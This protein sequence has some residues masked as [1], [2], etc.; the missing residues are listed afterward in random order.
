MKID[1]IFGIIY[2]LMKKDRLSARQLASH[3]E[4]ST[5]TI[6]RDIES[7]MQA[8]IPLYTSRG[9]EGG[10]SL[11]ENFTLD[12]A[13]LAPDE[14]ARILWSLQSLPKSHLLSS[15]W[16]RSQVALCFL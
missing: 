2:L 8:G 4:V 5:R 13:I 11:A 9:S 15:L 3:F 12:K 1:R 6:Q 7:L 14:Q 16:R 10:V